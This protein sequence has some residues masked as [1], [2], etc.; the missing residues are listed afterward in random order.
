MTDV[1]VT[2]TRNLFWFPV[3]SIC[4]CTRVGLS[5]CDSLPADSS[6]PAHQCLADWWIALARMISLFPSLPTSEL[7]P[8][9]LIHGDMEDKALTHT[10]LALH[11]PL[12]NSQYCCI[13]YFHTTHYRW[14]IQSSTSGP[15]IC[16]SSL[17]LL[18]CV[19]GSLSARRLIKQDRR[20]TCNVILRGIRVTFL[21]WRSNRYD[22]FRVRVCSLN[23]QACKARAFYYIIICDLPCC[24]TFPILYHKQHGFRETEKKV[25]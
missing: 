21:P 22:I 6:V 24:T 11:Q 25:V 17:H 4:C 19:M 16:N 5:W 2:D 7:L 14:K 15:S 1:K 13:I 3:Y 23:Y 10:K 18:Q 8:L 12:H 20:Y 9:I